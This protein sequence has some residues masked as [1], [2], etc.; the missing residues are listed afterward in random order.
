M[1]WG[2]E[3]GSLKADSFPHPGLTP[4]AYY[5]GLLLEEEP[6]LPRQL[7]DSSFLCM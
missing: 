4:E 1:G 3:G 6:A 7:E 5:P 2:G